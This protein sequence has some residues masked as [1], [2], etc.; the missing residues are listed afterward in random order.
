MPTVL[1]LREV[2]MQGCEHNTAIEGK[3][4]TW[5]KPIQPSMNDQ[6]LHTQRCCDHKVPK[7]Q[8]FDPALTVPGEVTL[9]V[10]V[11][12]ST[13]VVYVTPALSEH[14]KGSLGQFARST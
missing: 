11:V 9:A 1:M 14:R 7:H 12:S 2:M 6:L 5:Q 10:A 13:K 8:R 4:L 3:L